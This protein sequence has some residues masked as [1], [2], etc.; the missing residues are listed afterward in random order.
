MTSDMVAW[1]LQYERCSCCVRSYE[2]IRMVNRHMRNGSRVADGVYTNRL[3]SA[4][5][6]F[7]FFSLYS[8]S[9]IANQ[10]STLK[11]LGLLSFPDFLDTHIEPPVPVSDIT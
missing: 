8:F 4:L 2:K 9:F 11:H 6:D 7:L 3:L 1:L 5:E 10:V